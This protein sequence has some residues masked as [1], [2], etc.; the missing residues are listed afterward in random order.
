[1]FKTVKENLLLL[2]EDLSRNIETI[3]KNLKQI[4]ELKNII[5]KSKSSPDVINRKKSSLSK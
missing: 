5:F 2:T 3:K 4:I 1:M